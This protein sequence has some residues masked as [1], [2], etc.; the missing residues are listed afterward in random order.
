M[1][2]STCISQR[3]FWT[4]LHHQV[5]SC[6]TL[7]APLT[8][9]EFSRHLNVSL[10]RIQ[11]VTLLYDDFYLYISATLLDRPPPPGKF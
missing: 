8:L 7:K 5:N 4:D 6:S 2:I 10:L 3:H 1:M 11:E 9:K